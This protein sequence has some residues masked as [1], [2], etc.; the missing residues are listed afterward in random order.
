MRAKYTTVLGAVVAV[1]ALAAAVG[2]ASASAALPEF[3]NSGIPF[4]GTVNSTLYNGPGGTYSWGPAKVTEG[5]VG[6]P[7]ELRKVVISGWNT[8]PDCHVNEPVTTKPLKG[9][10]GYIT[11]TKEV[12]VLLEAEASPWWKCTGKKVIG[13]IIGRITPVNVKTTVFTIEYRYGAWPQEFQKFQG[14]EAT[15]S[16]ELFHEPSGPSERFG[17]QTTVHL[18]TCCNPVEIKA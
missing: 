2:P 18:T 16:L 10:L 7:S 17:L 6:L 3:S 13:S 1:V 15:H 5:F 4:T 14:E 11:A 12:G 9:R 8:N